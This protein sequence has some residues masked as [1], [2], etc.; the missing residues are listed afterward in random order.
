MELIEHGVRP[1]GLLSLVYNPSTDTKSLYF[2]GVLLGCISA[3]VEMRSSC[4]EI[5]WDAFRA[6]LS[7]DPPSGAPHFNCFIL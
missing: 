1:E 5:D 6:A 4:I 2:N 3:G 7:A